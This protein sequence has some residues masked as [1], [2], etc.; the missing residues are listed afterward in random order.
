[1]ILRIRSHLK[2][3]YFCN[4]LILYSNPERRVTGVACHTCCRQSNNMNTIAIDSA[5]GI[6]FES[7]FEAAVA[8][9]LAS[10][11]LLSIPCSF[12]I[13]KRGLIK[14]SH[15]LLHLQK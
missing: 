8:N 6:I 1:M 5:L 2:F 7:S 12:Q 14:L 11:L 10:F 9:F 3:S 13:T 4:Y 15:K